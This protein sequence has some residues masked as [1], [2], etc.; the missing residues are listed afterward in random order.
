MFCF[1]F[2]LLF[3]IQLVSTPG[4]QIEIIL[5]FKFL[6]GV[7]M[8]CILVLLLLVVILSSLQLFCALLPL[9]WMFKRQ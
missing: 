7:Y 6:N 2:L 4:S 3:A 5:S 8:T 1:V 9:N